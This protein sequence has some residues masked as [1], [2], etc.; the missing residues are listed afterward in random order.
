MQKPRVAGLLHKK[1]LN[2][3]Q[4]CLSKGM[5]GAR[6]AAYYIADAVAR[7]RT[8]QGFNVL[9]PIFVAAVSNGLVQVVRLVENCLNLSQVIRV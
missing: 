5:S 4:G 2:L 8:E 6:Q 3:V 9:A 7:L 1:N